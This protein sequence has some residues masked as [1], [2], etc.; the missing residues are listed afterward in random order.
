MGK[1]EMFRMFHVKRWGYVGTVHD[2]EAGTT[3]EGDEPARELFCRI[4]IKGLDY[5][6]EILSVEFTDLVDVIGPDGYVFD[7]H[8]IPTLIFEGV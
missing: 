2:F 5:P 8:G 1:T 7:F 6:A 4:V 3:F